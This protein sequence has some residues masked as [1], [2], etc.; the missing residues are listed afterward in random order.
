VTIRLAREEDLPVFQEIELAAGR[1]FAEIGMTEIADDDPPA[2]EIL[3]GFQRAGRAWAHVGADDVPDA[4][5][6]ADIVDGSAHIEQVSV[7]PDSAGKR[8]GRALIEHLAQWARQHGIGAM[9]LTTF[10]D[11]PWNGP[12]YQQGGFRFLADEEL[13]AGLRKIR[14]AE[15]ARGLDE[16]PRACMRREL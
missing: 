7:H 3:T 10:T 11:V 5:L 16:W 15:I 1:P 13:T 8:I 4:Y 12:Y 6:L 2:L 14:A 9:T